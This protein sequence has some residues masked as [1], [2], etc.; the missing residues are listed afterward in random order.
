M[1][2]IHT[3]EYAG[4]LFIWA[5]EAVESSPLA[6]PGRRR[7]KG[8]HA[9]PHPF[10]SGGIGLVHA[11][12]RAIPG[13]EPV[14]DRVCEITAW[15][16]SRGSSPVPSSPLISE[17]PRSRARLKFPPWTVPA[18]R[19]SSA[20]AVEILS[21]T[22][23]RITLAPGVVVGAD[24]AYWA[25]ALRF[26]GSVVARQQFLPGLTAVDGDYRAVWCPVFTGVD[27]ER[28]AE[29][30]TRMPPSARALSGPDSTEPPSEWRNEIVG[31]MVASLTDH[32]V[33]TAASASNYPMADRRLDGSSF[34]SAHD[35]WVHAL[36]SADGVV[37]GDPAE[38]AQLA[39]QIR[40]W[41]RPIAVTANSPF[42]L[43]FRLEEPLGIGEDHSDEAD[44]YWRIR[45][46]LQSHDDPSL[47]IP[48]EEA[49]NDQHVGMASPGWG[50]KG[51]REFLLS[52]LGQA[53]GI[54]PGVASSLEEADLSGYRLDTVEAHRFLA[55]DSLAL[56]QAG[57]GVLLPAWWTR[58]GTKVRLS[59]RAANVRVPAMQGGSGV[60]LDSILRFDWEVSMGS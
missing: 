41:R 12:N 34:A 20:E 11:L 16:P 53:S 25:D 33:R 4:S 14:L 55:E 2:I 59:A 22:I 49:W 58:K 24:T 9:Y 5:E 1:L 23:D 8:T 42:R 13:F 56:E 52:S 17:P 37:R 35:A 46:L 44:D 47:L 32:L 3:G 7:T 43:C 50:S 15:L 45:Y 54:C 26:A 27:A 48:A 51:A 57:Y 6:V 10:G 60:D 19:L 30:A 36:R 28:L 31:R 29:L 18:Y 40:E 38:L 39:A 21:A